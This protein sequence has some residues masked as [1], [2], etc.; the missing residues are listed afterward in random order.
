MRTHNVIL[1]FKPESAD[2][3]R[4]L[5]EWNPIILILKLLIFPSIFLLLIYIISKC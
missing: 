2:Y 5:T 1:T 3:H 4:S